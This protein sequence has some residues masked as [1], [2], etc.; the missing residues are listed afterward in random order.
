Q[1]FSGGLVQFIESPVFGLNKLI[2]FYE[3]WQDSLA[4]GSVL[5]WRYEDARANVESSLKEVL[6]F[7]RLP[8]VDEV[9]SD[10]AMFGSFE[11]MKALELSDTPLRYRSSGFNIFASGDLSNPDAFHVRR[12]L[13]EGFREK[14]SGEDAAR[15]EAVI[16]NR[17][18]ASYG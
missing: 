12:R 14:L 8:I 5:L 3:L 17:L 13:V 1:P 2:A 9:I 6:T 11:N 18:P 7:L 15:F 4:Q 16:R 10:A